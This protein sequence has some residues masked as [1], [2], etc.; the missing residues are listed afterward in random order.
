MTILINRKRKKYLYKNQDLHTNLGM[1]KSEDIENN[2]QGGTVRTN[3][4]ER[5]F[6]A[7]DCY[8]DHYQKIKRIAQIIPR[9]DIGLIITE[10]SLNKD[11]V[12]IETGA[13]SGGF[14]LLI[15]KIVKKVISYEI[16]E[17]F[18]E[19]VEKNISE[20]GLKNIKVKLRDSKQGF[21]EKNVD[22]ILLDVPDPWEFIE[23]VKGSL[24]IGGFLVN[25]SPSIPQVMDFVEASKED[26]AVLKT[27]EILEREWE[28]NSRKVRPLTQGIGHSGFL[29]FCRRLK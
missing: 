27:S 4:G 22:C 14:S 18:K 10:A 11:S 1:V 23:A 19:I 29:T 20:L 17:D 13:G 6:V 12:V 25:Y 8:L 2:K 28:I 9:K 24:K 21:D 26:F 5:F 7:Q 15:A 16:R 3:K